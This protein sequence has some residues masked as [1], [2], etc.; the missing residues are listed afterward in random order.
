MPSSTGALLEYTG[1]LL[2]HAEARTALDG[3]GH[4]VPVLCLDIELPTP[5]HTPLH[6]QQPFPAGHHAQA[7]AAAHRLKRG[8]VVT[9][10]T[11][12]AGMRLIAQN[13]VHIH[14]VSHPPK[15]QEPTP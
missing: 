12:L 8:M 5:D 2:H 1:V 7:E 15:E 4:G 6:I 3:A 9:V 13:A 10:Q 11:P 14:V